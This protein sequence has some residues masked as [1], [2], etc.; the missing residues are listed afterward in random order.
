LNIENAGTVK[1][2]I[3]HLGGRPMDDRTYIMER[4]VR[5]ASRLLLASYAGK[6][7]TNS[8]LTQFWNNLKHPPL[9]YLGEDFMYRKADGSNNNILWPHIGAAGAPYARTVKPSQLQPIAL[10]DPGVVFDSLLARKDFKEH[11]NKISN[12]L[13]YLAS[14]II[15]YLSNEPQRLQ[16]IRYIFLFRPRSSLWKQSGRTGHEDV[17]IWQNQT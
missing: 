6:R 10:P 5:L 3:A 14:I 1:G 9:S 7:V 15:R 17:Q 2:V 11:P 12:V 8:F 16:H 4:V 13:F